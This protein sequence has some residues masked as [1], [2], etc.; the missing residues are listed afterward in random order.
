MRLSGTPAEDPVMRLTTTLLAA[1]AVAAACIS[2]PVAQAQGNPSVDQIVK[3]LTPTQ[4]GPSTRGIHINA[5]PEVSL[6]VLFAT[7]SAE[8]T[9]QAIQTLNDLG[10]ALTD[11]T[12][13]AYRFR[14][15]GHTD[16]VGNRNANK[17]LSDRRA[18]SVVDYLAGRFQVDRAR[19]QPVGMGEDGLLVSTPDQTPEPR[20]RRVLVVN[21]G[22]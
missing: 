13:A 20:N 4:G 14:I 18:A 5:P 8:L 16:T 6:S 7:G 1:A 10:R 19:L 15:E 22:S 11:P 2:S 12:L 3:S 17:A 9:P 21:T